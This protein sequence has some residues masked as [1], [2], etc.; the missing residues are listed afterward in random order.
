MRKCIAAITLLSA[1]LIA[2][3][4][5]VLVILSGNPDRLRD[6]WVWWIGADF[7]G[8]KGV[9]LQK[10]PTSCGP[11]ALKVVLE[12]FGISTSLPGLQL[13]A[14]IDRNQGTS[15]L[16]LK[17]IAESYGL[18]AEGWHLTFEDL[19]R[20]PMPAIVLF[21]SHHFVVVTE[22]DEERNVYVLD[23]S[24]GRLRFSRSAFVK[25]WKGQTLFFTKRLSTVRKIFRSASP[26]KGGNAT[27]KPPNNPT[28]KTQKGGLA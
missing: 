20:T 7:L 9:L 8:T 22:I 6:A 4:L 27:T 14:S 28:H 23:P 12:R 13:M 24:I 25:N 10:D 1:A 26:E 15:M 2:G 17:K 5:V 21:R 19:S 11:T 3:M 18:M 16:T